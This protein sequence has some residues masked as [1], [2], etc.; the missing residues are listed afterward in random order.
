MKENPGCN[1]FGAVSALKNHLMA[2]D[3]DRWNKY[4]SDVKE[5]YARDNAGYMLDEPSPS[6]SVAQEVNELARKV[7]L[8]ASFGSL[9]EILWDLNRGNYCQWV[10][11]R[12]PL[13]L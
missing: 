10:G 5:E 6:P 8:M 11:L 7:I 9:I 13:K 1:Y 3:N 2:N 12:L 4:L